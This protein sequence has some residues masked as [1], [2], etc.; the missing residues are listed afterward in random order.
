M[1]EKVHEEEKDEKGKMTTPAA[2]VDVKAEAGKGVLSTPSSPQL[3]SWVQAVMGGAKL[4]DPVHTM[5]IRRAQEEQEEKRRRLIEC[6]Q[7]QLTSLPAEMPTMYSY[8]SVDGELARFRVDANGALWVRLPGASVEKVGA[9]TGN[10]PG[11]HN[12]RKIE[13]MAGDFDRAHY[14]IARLQMRDEHTSD[15]AHPV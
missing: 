7:S 10:C 2:M 4:T 14:F 9:P 3:R 13:G 12:I 1:E 6:Q 5:Q 11:Y 8:A 15:D